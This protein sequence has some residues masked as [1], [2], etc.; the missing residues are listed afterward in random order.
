[1]LGI[2]LIHLSESSLVFEQASLSVETAFLTVVKMH[3]N[4]SVSH[5]H[6]SNP[7]THIVI[8][9]HSAFEY[10]SSRENIATTLLTLVHVIVN[11]DSSLEPQFHMTLSTLSPS[12]TR[13]CPSNHS[14]FPVTPSPCALISD[15]SLAPFSLVLAELELVPQEELLPS[16]SLEQFS[17][18]EQ[19]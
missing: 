8:Y 17:S 10:T 15:T 3:R 14:C 11:L 4:L 7:E 9:S 1:M 12:L 2:S 6:N 16:L 19:L 13:T 18:L 5:H